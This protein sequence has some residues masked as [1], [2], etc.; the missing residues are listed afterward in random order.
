MS[1]TS[2]AQP[3]ANGLASL[4]LAQATITTFAE[5]SPGTRRFCL[6]YPALKCRATFIR[7]YGTTEKRFFAGGPIE[8]SVKIKKLA[9]RHPERSAAGSKDQFLH[10]EKRQAEL[11][12]RQAQDDGILKVRLLQRSPIGSH[13]TKKRPFPGRERL[14]F[15][16]R[17]FL[18]PTHGYR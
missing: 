13:L 4:R 10:S 17:V 5:V 11:I 7:S 12:L 16:S 9:S 6:S 15:S 2:F 8:T 3:P 18:V 14:P 1:L